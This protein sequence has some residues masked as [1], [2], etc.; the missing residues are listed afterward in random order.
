MEEKNKIIKFSDLSDQE[1]WDLE[2]RAKKIL[3]LKQEDHI[4]KRTLIYL[5]KT[6]KIFDGK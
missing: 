2:K 5:I 4:N 1:L 3:C 6:K